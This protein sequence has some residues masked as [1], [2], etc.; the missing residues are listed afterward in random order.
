MSG[1][2]CKGERKK[3]RDRVRM[4]DDRREPPHRVVGFSDREIS[5]AEIL[6]LRGRR[7]INII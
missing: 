5:G 7:H 4:R 2:D 3:E 1:R 6:I